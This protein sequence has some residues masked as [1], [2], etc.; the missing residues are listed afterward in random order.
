[1]AAVSNLAVVSLT[2]II[3]LLSL[4]SEV[5]GA[6]FTLDYDKNTFLKDGKPFRYVS[7][8]IHYSRVPQAYWKDRLLKMYAAGL[9]AIQL[10]VPW[11]IHQ[12]EK[13]V[14]D[15]TGQQ[16]LVAFLKTAQDVGLL[17]VMRAGPYICGEWDFGGFPAWILKE[18][19]ATVFRTMDPTY[20]KFV[21]QW[22]DVL[23]PKL[24]PL[25]YNNGG[26]IIMVQI[27]NEYGSYFACDRNYTSHLRD[28]ARFHLGK[29]VV[30]FT[31]D[32]ASDGFLKCGYIPEVYAT[33]DF[34]VTLN[35]EAS[36]KA[37][38]DYEPKGPLV[39]SE[40][41]TGWLDHWGQKHS[42]TDTNKVAASL[43]LLL[44]YGA[45]IN[46][47]MFEGGTNFGFWNGANYSPFQPVPT[48][49][50]YDGPLTEAGDITT[51]YIE[52]R[53]IISK[54]RTLP[55]IPIPPSTKK[56]RYGEVNMKFVSTLQDAITQLSPKGP[57]KSQYPV[58]MES[59]GQYQGFALYRHIL[60]KSVVSQTLAVPGVR[61]RGYVMV[62]KVPQGVIIR[63]KSASV[64]ITG[65]QG[66]T[67]D[68]L[69]E[70]QGHINYGSGINNN[71]KGIIQNVTLQGE[72]LTDWA[73]FP[74]SLDNLNPSDISVVDSPKSGEGLM[75][76]S[77]YMGK[78]TISGDPEDTY[79]DMTGW[80]K[81]QVLLKDHINLGRYW[82]KEGPQVRL[83]V[84]K[85]Y[86][87]AN[88]ML[89]MFEL[90]GAPCQTTATC[91]V[92]FVD[93]P[94]INGTNSL[95]GQREIGEGYKW[96]WEH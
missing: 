4:C 50:D 88:N 33:V 26:P 14:Y 91:V 62:D 53:Q 30:L 73:V 22:M 92:N 48:S 63:E 23:L 84:P 94:L 68:I 82:P 57:I 16:D 6:N 3:S 38:R 7:G 54:Y 75:T 9:N 41:Y 59:V 81:G 13:D 21:D 61:D 34:G 27:E 20:I 1:M 15:F 96:H 60:K 25:L 78:L 18:N 31:T 89:L 55:D 28:R 2:T 12:P 49:Y 40:F 24:K 87:T 47:Y 67:L 74:L 32:G 95:S 66:S 36:F 90:E 45:N 72:V 43:D 69:V 29:D 19:P 35:P 44:D 83:F 76:P 52:L 11:N 42:V 5:N 80:T 65:K 85:P 17:V 39:N 70:N 56:A 37:Q 10:Y 58:T 86:L 46:M 71:T 64:T 77:I 51:K 8:S 79:L 93:Q